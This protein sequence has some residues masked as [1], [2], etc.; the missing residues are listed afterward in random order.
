MLDPFL[1]KAKK[2]MHNDYES[3]IYHNE[4]CIEA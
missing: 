3:D 4:P 2:N 1:K